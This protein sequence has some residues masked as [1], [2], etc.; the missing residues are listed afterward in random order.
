MPFTAP[1]DT[2]AISAIASTLLRKFT[3]GSYLLRPGHGQLGILLIRSPYYIRYD[4]PHHTI[5]ATSSSEK[6]SNCPDS[7]SR[8][9]HSWEQ[10]PQPVDFTHD[11]SNHGILNVNKYSPPLFIQRLIFKCISS[12]YQGRK[13]NC[14]NRAN[15][16]N[17]ADGPP[18][19]NY[20]HQKWHFQGI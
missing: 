17:P 2:G 16:T 8:K 3:S 20:E 1:H 13:S 9:K 15:E 11:D 10:S 4:S 12:R 6:S 14:N 5:C 19:A 18:C 7:A